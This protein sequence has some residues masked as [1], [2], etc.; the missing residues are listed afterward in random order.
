M[1]YYSGAGNTKYIANIIENKL[2]KNNHNIKTIKISEKNIGL[3]DNNFDILFLVF[4]EYF[5]II[6]ELAHK[7]LR[8][9]SWARLPS[10]AFAAE[11]PYSGNDLK[12]LHKIS[13]EN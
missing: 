4:P 10:V 9:S 7:I 11:G 12:Q 2:V 1:L 6:P 13:L 5:R 8:K 3:L